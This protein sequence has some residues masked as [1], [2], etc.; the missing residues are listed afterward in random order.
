MEKIVHITLDVSGMPVP[1]ED[2][3]VLRVGDGVSWTAPFS[4]TIAI[5]D[6]PELH[7]TE[8]VVLYDAGTYKYSIT[9]NGRTNDPEIVVLSDVLEMLSGTED[10]NDW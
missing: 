7:G 10:G 2:P 4:F 1:D 6:F 8:T 9:A 5:P 3:V